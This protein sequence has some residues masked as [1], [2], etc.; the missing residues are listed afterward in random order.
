MAERRMFARSV[1]D[2]DRFLDMPVDAQLLY[3]HLGMRADDDGF[4]TPKNVMRL[5]GARDDSLKLLVAKG[6][7]IPFRSGVTVITHWKVNNYLQK[8]R[9]RETEFAAEKALLSMNGNLYEL[10]A[11]AAAALPQAGVPAATVADKPR[12]AKRARRAG[13]GIVPRGRDID[14]TGEYLGELFEEG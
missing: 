12:K 1:V 10:K 13:R 4:V 7:A 11:G 14:M 2:D 9:Y 5:I 3:F 8:D 6:Y